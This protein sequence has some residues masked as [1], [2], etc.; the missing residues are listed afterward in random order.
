[1]IQE[2]LKNIPNRRF[3]KCVLRVQ[4]FEGV[5][6]VYLEAYERELFH[7]NKVDDHGNS[8]MHI[9]A[10]NGALRIAK[11]LFDK[12][13]NPNHQNK[14]GQTPGHFAVAYQFFDFASWLFDERGANADDLLANM[15]GLG[16]YDGLITDGSL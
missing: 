3:D 7:L 13:A 16:P 2:A 12:G 9:A 1:L 11:L 5:G 10:Q 4:F 8:P 14:Q 6:T 15:Y